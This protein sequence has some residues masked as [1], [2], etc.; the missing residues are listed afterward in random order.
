MK[1]EQ[2]NWNKEYNKFI[3]YLFSLQDIKYKDFHYKLLNNNKIN[4]IGIKTPILKEIA[5]SISKGNY[6]EFIYNN[7]HK[8]YEETIIHGLIIGYKQDIISLNEFIKYIDNWA[9]NDIVASNMKYFKNNQQNGLK[10]INQYISNKNPWI[11][12]FGVVLLLNYYINET[13][14]D[15]VIKLVKSINNDNYY[16]KM[17]ISWLISICYIKY[18]NKTIELFKN[19]DFDKFIINK[20]IS[21]INDSHR[22][23]KA[24]KDLIKKYRI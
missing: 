15:E 16:V 21:K 19:N 3:K 13:Y 24:D 22:V 5:L 2:F 6:K 17:A 18:K 14:I 23:N 10:Y 1:L 8:Y 7:T 9:T 20:S 4:L 11:V 12:R